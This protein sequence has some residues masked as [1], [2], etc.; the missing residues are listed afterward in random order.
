MPYIQ[1]LKKD[2]LQIEQDLKELE[3]I[4]GSSV[5]NYPNLIHTIREIGVSWDKHEEKEEVFFHELQK[6]GFPVT[7][8][9]LVFEHGKLKKNREALI[10]AINTG[11]EQKIKAA[12]QSE[13][14]K[15]IESVRKHM[16]AEDWIL[17][18]LP[19]TM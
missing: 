9:K 4:M 19:Q 15:L 8:K 10:R 1:Q 12:L 7:V 3:T 16:A 11:S 14:R 17:Y 2:H 5:I 13:G 18:A 6:K